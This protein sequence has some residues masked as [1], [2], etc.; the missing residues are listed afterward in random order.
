MEAGVNEIDILVKNYLHSRGKF[1]LEFKENLV[2]S[3]YYEQIYFEE[4]K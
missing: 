2:M 4:E 3:R 1:P